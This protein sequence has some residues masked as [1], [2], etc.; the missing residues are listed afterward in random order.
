M[1]VEVMQSTYRAH[2]ILDWVKI[3]TTLGYFLTSYCLPVT[4]MYSELSPMVLAKG[5]SGAR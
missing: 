5:H 4:S 3:T 1:K 2:T